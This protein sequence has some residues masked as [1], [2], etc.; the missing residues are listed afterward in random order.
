[1]ENITSEEYVSFQSSNGHTLN[2]GAGENPMPRIGV[3]A[4]L[5]F[6]F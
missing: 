2:T 4:G 6:T 5:E 3:L 1:V